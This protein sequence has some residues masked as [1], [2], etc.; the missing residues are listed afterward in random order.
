[1]RKKLKET[2]GLLVL[3]AVIALA[4][5]LGIYRH[6]AKESAT[7]A[8]NIASEIRQEKPD[9]IDLSPVT[10]FDHKF[11]DEWTQEKV[12]SENE[13]QHAKLD[14]EQGTYVEDDQ[15]VAEEPALPEY[16]GQGDSGYTFAEAFADARSKLGAGQVFIWNSREFTTDLAH[17]VPADSITVDLASVDS[18]DLLAKNSSQPE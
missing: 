6:E 5:A 10:E 2:A 12:L 1:M 11:I 8:L 9:P 13:E 14:A 3:S 7:V 17:E 18:V 4:I 15:P 16:N